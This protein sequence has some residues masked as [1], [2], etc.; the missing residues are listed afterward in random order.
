MFGFIIAWI[1]YTG[2]R[3]A[4]CFKAT[5]LLPWALSYV[6]NSIM[7]NWLFHGSY[8]LLN[9]VLFRLKLINDYKSWLADPKA[10]LYV[11]IFMDIWKNIPFSALAFYAGLQSIPLQLFE[12]AKIDGASN[13]QMIR[14]IVLP[15]L[16]NL[17]TIVFLF[18]A[19]WALRGFDSIWTL[20]RGGFNTEILNITIYKETFLYLR[21][22]EGA[23][24]AFI[25]FLIT[26]IIMSSLLKKQQL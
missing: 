23:A 21:I 26:F 17:C 11:I 2:K 25:L 1:M 24:L 12:A 13:M 4:F 9:E 3:M 10:A 20:T 16:R 22:G 8:G 6:A 15:Y 7:W 19:I 14:Y 18:Q 5:F